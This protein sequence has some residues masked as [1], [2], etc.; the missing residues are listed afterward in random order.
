MTR[1][2]EDDVPENGSDRSPIHD[3]LNLQLL[4]DDED[5]FENEIPQFNI[6]NTESDT[7]S[8]SLSDTHSFISYSE[9]PTPS[10][11]DD[12]T[13]L[14]TSE[15]NSWADNDFDDLDPDSTS[16]SPSNSNDNADE[17]DP[18]MKI[19]FIGNITKYPSNY[20]DLAPALRPMA[21][22]IA[23]NSNLNAAQASAI[24]SGWFSTQSTYKITDDLK[25]VSL[26]EN[27]NPNSY[28]NFST[29]NL[30][31]IIKL[32]PSLRYFFCI[33]D[34]IGDQEQPY[35]KILVLT[36]NLHLLSS[37]DTSIPHYPLTKSLLH[38]LLQQ[39]RNKETGI[40]SLQDE[41]NN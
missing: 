20:N 4:S 17:E 3:N 26:I 16:S 36:Y 19:I 14:A 33:F 21:I 38:S 8:D 22:K 41:S 7:G 25:H 27:S 24:T 40:G 13:T 35:N 6:F 29:T 12:L 37:L 2:I 34:I 11:I 39:H 31:N 32:D 1:L 18:D 5:D 30:W 15:E 28:P 9:S 23:A 10:N